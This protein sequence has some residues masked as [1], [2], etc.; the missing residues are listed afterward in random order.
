MTALSFKE[1][2]IKLKAAMI[3]KDWP[4]CEVLVRQTIAAVAENLERDICQRTFEQVPPKPARRVYPILYLPVEIKTREW[5]GK[6][7]LAAAAAKRGFTVVIGQSWSIQR[8]K[9]NGWPPGI[10]LFKTLNSLDA[11][12]MGGAIG[13]GHLVATI[14]E[15]SFARPA[16][17]KLCKINTDP[18]SAACADLILAQGQDHADVLV[19]TYPKV[20]DKI[21]V[22]GNP[23]MKTITAVDAVPPATPGYAL[24]CSMAGCI[25]NLR[26]FSTCTYS[27]L[28]LTGF[29]SLETAKNDYLD[30]CMYELEI[31]PTIINETIR[32]AA[33]YPRV[34]FRPHPMESHDIWNKIFEDAP[35]ISVSNEGA[36]Q[37]WMQHAG[38][39]VLVEN[40]GCMVEARAIG[41]AATVLSG[42]RH[43]FPPFGNEHIADVD[44]VENIARE[45]S[46]LYEANK[47]PGDTPNIERKSDFVAKAF[48]RNKFPVT[49]LEDISLPGLTVTEIEENVFM[50]R[51]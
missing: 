16:T 31:M 32:A 23:R 25:N 46:K 21:V 6:L 18:W 15:E 37:S 11:L 12:H 27:T 3:A 47:Q 38:E 28:H 20:A 2:D 26:G 50:V 39:V 48:H 44:A 49:A 8:G 9:Y 4:R 5:T 43:K 33:S 30:C 45:I 51:A 42:K 10:V 41:K 22:T 17:E 1:A 7:A 29:S 36:V 34:V 13:S 19:A 35:R 40:C 24:I 14:D